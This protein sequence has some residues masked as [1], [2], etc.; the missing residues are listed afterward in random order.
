[1]PLL[2]INHATCTR[3]YICMR[4]CPVNAIDYDK[5]ND[6][7]NIIEERCIACGACFTDCPV[8][9]ISYQDSIVKVKRLLDEDRPVFIVCDTDISAEFTDIS[10][11]RKFVS[12]LKAVGFKKVFSTALA[13]DLV[14]AQYKKLFDKEFKG[15]YYL[16]ANCPVVV[17]LVERYY[18]HLIG[19]LAPIL[20]P[21]LLA[22]KI[23]REQF[24][25][26]DVALVYLTPCLAH[27]QDLVRDELKT[28]YDTVLLFPEIRK[29]FDEKNIQ[30][31]QVEFSDFDGL[32][33]KKGLLY[34]ISRGILEAGGISESLL[35]GNIRNTNGMQNVMKAIGSFD[36]QNEILHS[37]LN[38]FFCE[39]CVMGPG[40]MHDHTNKFVRS[41]NV[42]DYAKKRLENFDEDE[43]Q[44][45]MDEWK[46]LDTQA[47]F[48]AKAVPTFD[49][50]K[51]QLFLKKADQ[52][53]LVLTDS[54]SQIDEADYRTFQANQ[55]LHTLINQISSGVAIV[56]S[57]M[58]I[59]IANDSLITTIGEE[60][61]AIAEV[62]PGLK[63]AN[64]DTMLDKSISNLFDYVLRHHEN[65]DRK[66]V[67]INNIPLILSV[68][69]IIENK[70]VGGIFRQMSTQKLD[71]DEL[72]LSIQKTIDKN[73][74]MVQEIGF[75]LGEGASNT[76]KDLNQIIKMLKQEG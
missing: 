52:K 71:T 32:E 48:S 10:D 3:C 12:M 47:A 38:L 24:K 53:N 27:K 44:E 57:E 58:K 72:V 69:N 66:E 41:A 62:I 15:K 25:K 29:L 9:A 39:G 42:V 59:L 6:E 20:A 35:D 30:E 21:D 8:E 76:E 51:Y 60:V 16:S 70:L 26:T 64:L 2:S 23:I 4:S 63:G 67:R 14:A 17:N 45:E 5:K 54:Q 56:D 74:T 36:M 61:A 73:L 34:P 65:I 13:V 11:Y 1:M 22:A 18:P 43:W 28:K 37:H 68:F 55:A 50:Q 46:D 75:V 33:G 7:L 19:N 49:D 40:T 31:R